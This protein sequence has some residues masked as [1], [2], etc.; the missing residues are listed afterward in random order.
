MTN[1]AICGRTLTNPASISRG[2]GPI[3]GERN[4]L[5]RVYARHG[6]RGRGWSSIAEWE[7]VNYPC[8]SCK[9]FIVPHS[10]A[11]SSTADGLKVT[12]YGQERTFTDKTAMGGWCKVAKA[13]VDGNQINTEVDCN[14][15]EYQRRDNKPRLREG[16]LVT[17]TGQILIPFG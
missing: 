4:Y 14:G 5:S 6:L 8:Y 16:H 12:I 17:P 11:E 7:T 15:L 10:G 1:C 13:I 3:C 2:V 9:H